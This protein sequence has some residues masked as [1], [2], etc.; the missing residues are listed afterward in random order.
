MPDLEDTVD[1]HVTGIFSGAYDDEDVGAETG[2]NNL[3][4]IM[5]VS[6]IP[7]TIIHKDH[8]KDHIIGD[9]NSATQTRRMTKISEELAMASYIKKHRRTNHKDYQNCLF[10]YFL[11]QIEPKKK[12]WRLVDLPKGKHAIETKWVYRNKKDERGIVVRNKARLIAQGYTKEEGIDYDEVF[13]LV[14]RIEAIRLFLAY[15]SFMGFIV[16]QMDVKSAFLYGTIEEEV[17][18]CQPPSFEDP[19]FSD[20]VYKVYVD[21]II[22]GS[23][24]KS[25][26]TEF[27]GLMHKKFQMNSMRELTF[28]LGLQ[29]MQ[30]DDG[31]F[32]S[33]DK[34]VADILKSFN[35]ATVK[36]TSTPIETNKA[37]LKDE[38]VEDVDVHLYRSMIGSLMYLTA[39]RPDI[40][41]A[42]CACARFQVTPK[43]S[44]LHA[45]K[46]IFRYLKGNPQQEVV[47]FLAKGIGSGDRSQCA[48]KQLGGAIAQLALQDWLTQEKGLAKAVMY[49]KRGEKSDSKAMFK[50]SDFDVLDDAMENVKGGSTTE[51]ITTAG[52]TLN[53]ASINVSTAGP[54]NGSAASPSTSTTG[55][56]F[57]DE[58]TTIAD[59]LVDIR[60]ARPRTTLVVIRN[61]EEEPRRATSVPTVQ[62]QEKEREQ[63]IARERAAKQEAKDAALIK[64]ME[65]VQS[66]KVDVDELKKFFAAQRA[67]EIRNMPPT[68]TQLRNQMITYLKH[69]SKYTHNQ[70]K[71]KSFEEIQKLYKKEQ[72][73]I[74]DLA[75]G[76]SKNYKIFS[77]NGDD[78][79][80]HKVWILI[81]LVKERYDTTSPE[82]YDLLLWGDIEDHYLSV[83]RKM[84]VWR[85]TRLHCDSWDYL[86]HVEFMMLNRRLEVDHE[87][88]MAFELLRFTRSQ[89]KK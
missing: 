67:A 59:T 73:W 17:Y 85:N 36:T 55:D 6:H 64:Q 1:L 69:M 40:I 18:V 9:I 46:R 49:P 38:E 87:S 19:Q 47:N 81:R 88:E 71:S 28:F 74:N 10:A 51:Q 84:D 27:E 53:T 22:F 32:I 58:M 82:G 14:A 15:A 25:L 16:Y 78:F 68:R 76:S 23:T 26:C 20:K 61:V 29:V 70:L 43:V 42:V 72:Q 24:K 37:L 2:L 45:V 75:D 63:R 41:F 89:L 50:D 54:S 11:S 79:D 4:T 30:R 33:Q 5:N 3:E 52:D 39:S 80:R 60:S 21:D 66:K 77:K 34:Y 35:F 8:P 12:V 56:I 31:I 44:H 57:K 62:S 13:A 65:D 83:V 48:K 7:T 86:T